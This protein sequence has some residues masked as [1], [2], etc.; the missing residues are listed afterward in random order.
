[1]NS[2]LDTN[3]NEIKTDDMK[4]NNRKC[5]ETKIKTLLSQLGL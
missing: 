5:E 1:M 2:K 3:Q 4:K